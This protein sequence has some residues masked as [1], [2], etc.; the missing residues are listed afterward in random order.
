MSWWEYCPDPYDDLR[1]DSGDYGAHPPA[2]PT[3]KHCGKARLTW[4]WTPKGWRLF[5]GYGTPHVCKKD[6]TDD[7]GDV[8]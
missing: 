1:D 5:E 3:C 4:G 7:F 6:S 8:A 2:K